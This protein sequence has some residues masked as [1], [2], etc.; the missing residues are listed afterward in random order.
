[1]IDGVAPGWLWLAAA[2]LLAGAE[3]V[4]PGVFLI[5]FAVAAAIVAGLTLAF[6][7]SPAVQFI[8]FGVAAGVAV[9]AGRAWYVGNPVD[10]DDPLLNDRGAR[11]IGTTVTVQTAIE[12]GSGR[13]LVGDGVWP[14]RGEDAAAGTRLRVVGLEDGALVVAPL[15]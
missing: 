8:T 1:M 13:V 10:S 6:E 7:P 2:V 4:V 15:D 3:L 5:W 14:A 12:G 9:F 11:L